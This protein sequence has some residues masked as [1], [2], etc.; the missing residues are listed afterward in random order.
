MA[1]AVF[2]LAAVAKPESN[3]YADDD[4]DSSQAEGN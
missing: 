3:P 1:A 4:V 2:L